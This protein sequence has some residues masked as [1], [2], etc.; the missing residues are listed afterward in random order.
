[1]TPSWRPHAQLPPL[2]L[3]PR[4]PAGHRH[5]RRRLRRGW[6]RQRCPGGRQH[7]PAGRAGR[8]RSHGTDAVW[9]PLPVDVLH[10]GRHQLEH[11]LAHQPG[12]H[13]P[14]RKHR[15]L[16]ARAQ[17]LERAGRL[18]G[19]HAPDGPLPLRGPVP[20][21]R[22]R[23]HRQL[24]GRHQQHGGDQRRDRREGGPLVRAR[25]RQHRRRRL[26]LHVPSRRPLDL[27][28]PLCRGDAQ[29]R[30]HQRHGLRAQ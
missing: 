29:P 19:G 13:H 7:P 15:R 6:Q 5:T 12:P 25:R 17:V 20:G 16:P 8:L 22:P 11:R 23:R 9:P 21:G 26:H 2:S 3:T 10:E 28:R 30:R 27:R 1:M 4:R 14:S 24:A 18:V